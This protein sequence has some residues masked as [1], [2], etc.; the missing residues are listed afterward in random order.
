MIDLIICVL[1]L[2]KIELHAKILAYKLLNTQH[3]QRW[4]LDCIQ[5]D[6]KITVNI[7]TLKYSKVF[8]EYTQ[9]ANAKL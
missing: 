3:E 9:M 6:E 7:S 8:S 2:W 1:I 4:N 5:K